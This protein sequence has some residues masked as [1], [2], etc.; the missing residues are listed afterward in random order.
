MN[1]VLWC[2]AGVTIVLG[3]FQTPLQEFL[4]RAGGG[5]GAPAHHGWLPVAACLLA[6][7]AISRPGSNSA[8]KKPNQIGWVERIPL[9][10]DLFGQR[11]YLDRL[12]R[13]LLDTLVYR[14]VSRCLRPMTGV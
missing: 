4:A 3:F 5:A 12:Y 1:A 2:L 11:W 6:A 10:A 13:F 14:G 7:V 8:A 9:L